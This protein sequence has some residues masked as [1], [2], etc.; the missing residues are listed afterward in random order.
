MA[1]LLKQVVAFILVEVVVRAEAEAG[2]IVVNILSV[3]IITNGVIQS[4]PKL[5]IPYSLDQCLRVTA[6]HPRMFN[7]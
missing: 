1:A 5:T 2:A 7:K 4:V 6:F 3:G